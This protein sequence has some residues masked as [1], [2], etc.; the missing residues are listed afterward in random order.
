MSN[1]CFVSKLVQR[2]VASQLMDLD[3]L[4]LNNLLPQLQSAYRLH[5][6]GAVRQS[7]SHPVGLVGFKCSIRLC[8]SRR[9]VIQ[10]AV[11]FWSSRQG[12]RLAV[13]PDRKVTTGS[14]RWLSSC[15]AAYGVSYADDNADS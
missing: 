11:Q 4:A 15:V 14:A 12:S 13:I 5:A 7:D 6:E 2:I 3:Y 1:L 8:R 9:T 10:A